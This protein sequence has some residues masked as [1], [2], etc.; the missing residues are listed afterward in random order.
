I[1]GALNILENGHQ[2]RD[3]DVMYCVERAFLISLSVGVGANSIVGIGREDKQQYGLFAYYLNG[4]R[5]F[6]EIVPQSFS[7]RL[8][9]EWIH[10]AFIE[11]AILNMGITGFPE[12][13]LGGRINPDDGK[14][15]LLT[16]GQGSIPERAL[17][18]IK[19][20]A[21]GL[22]SWI[23][24]YDIHQVEI[25]G[26]SNLVVQGDGDIIGN[27]PVRVKVL[28]KAIPVIVPAK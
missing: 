3:L 28:P 17:Q 13:F 10:G 11:V 9:G 7:L 18:S 12:A 22:D 19:G 2:V 16:M 26:D 6:L 8:D 27:L 5:Q 20:R 25:H 21:N 24:S 15:R 4:A 1:E 23:Q 14:L